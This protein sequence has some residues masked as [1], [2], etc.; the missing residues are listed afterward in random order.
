MSFSICKE[1]HAPTGVEFCVSAYLTHVKGGENGDGGPFLP[2]LIVVKEALLEVYAVRRSMPANCGDAEVSKLEL[3]AE[4]P[5]H[6][7]VQSISVL[8]PRSITNSK[9][10]T[11]RDALLLTFAEAKLSVVEFDPTDC[12]LCTS[13]L[14]AY[15][16]AISGAGLAAPPL[17]PLL[18]PYVTSDPNGRCAAVL[19]PTAG[20][21]FLE[22]AQ[23]A[24]FL[25]E[26]STNQAGGRAGT[27]QS[28]AIASSY[29]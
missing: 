9:D 21:A 14:H 7:T 3:I 10:T 8:Q 17:R 5:L 27:G 2:D 4:Y 18:A 24:T 15:E 20:L 16:K 29:V 19:L 12:R 25:A 28:A 22:S 23:D 11:K 13:S 6:G 26:T 1:L